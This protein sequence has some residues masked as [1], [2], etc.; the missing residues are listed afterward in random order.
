M[1]MR[2]TE[3]TIQLR[4]VATDTH[5]GYGWGQCEHLDQGYQRCDMFP[6]GALKF[7]SDAC[8]YKRLPECIAAE[9]AQEGGGAC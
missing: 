5:C 8:T 3:R 6:H 1:S 9:N 4:I 2:A 7:D